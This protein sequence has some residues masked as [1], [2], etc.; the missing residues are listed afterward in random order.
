MMLGF[1]LLGF[2]LL[3]FALSTV[4][5]SRLHIMAPFDGQ[6]L[7]WDPHRTTMR[8]R[9]AVDAS[10]ADQVRASGTSASANATNAS[11]CFRLRAF[12]GELCTACSA[13]AGRA[14]TAPSLLR[15]ERPLIL[16]NLPAGE[17]SLSAEIRLATG[18]TSTAPASASASASPVPP[19]VLARGAALF[20][21]QYGIA[22]PA[23]PLRVGAHAGAAAGTRARTRTSTRASTPIVLSHAALLGPM[24]RR[25]AHAHLV[26]P[27]ADVRSGARIEYRRAYTDVPGRQ[28]F[29]L[30]AYLAR[31]LARG[32]GV[33]ARAGASTGA[34]KGK[35]EDEGKGE[36]EGEDE[37]EGEGGGT[38]AGLA[39]AAALAVNIG[40]ADTAGMHALAMA[41]AD[42]GQ[43]RGRA[44]RS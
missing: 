43:G 18:T 35:G 20:R 21:V 10:V 7:S 24:G 34:G 42:E 19:A 38:G 13:R 16:E 15:F 4:W 28:P 44:E 14:S 1:S 23:P 25:T 26:Q 30:L 12:D 39:C 41:E 29:A 40:V 2:A 3:G 32:G 27:V 11:I 17:H 36:G 33:G 5:A 31:A 9:V 37:G 8:V 22:A 6:R